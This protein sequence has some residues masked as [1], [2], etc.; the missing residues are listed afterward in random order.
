MKRTVL[1]RR[2]RSSSCWSRSSVAQRA[3][4]AGGQR[5]GAERGAG[6]ALR[7]R[8]VLAQAAAEPLAARQRH[9][10]LGR[11]AGSGV[12]RPPRLGT[13]S[14][15]NEKALELKAGDC[16]AGAPGGARLRPPGQSGQALGRAGTGLR[17]AGV[18]PRHLRRSH[19]HGVDRRQ[20][21]GRLA[22]HE[23]HAGRQVRRAVR[24]AER[25]ADRQE[26][27][28]TADR[29]RRTAA[30]RTTSAASRRSSSIPRPTK[31]TSPTATSTGA[32]PCSMPRPAR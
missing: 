1:D 11:R 14:S 28:G 10:R 24:Q 26:R 21:P 6:A 23:V 19:R 15:N 31:P 18:E 27:E 2:R 7:G 12:D 8:P 29:S 3:V 17:L 4:A 30:T 5:A 25:A 13:R 20:R 22:H 9:R 32:S 16:C